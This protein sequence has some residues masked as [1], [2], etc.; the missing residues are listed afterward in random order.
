MTG[1]A[2]MGYESEDQLNK[3]PVTRNNPF[4]QVSQR[5][6]NVYQA[7]SMHNP[8]NIDLSNVPATIL[9]VTK[10]RDSEVELAVTENSRQPAWDPS[11]NSN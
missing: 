8:L 3:S 7:R 1:G 5:L 2:G 4:K 9:Q 11:D 6:G 10:I